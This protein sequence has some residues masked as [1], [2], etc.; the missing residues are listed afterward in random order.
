MSEDAAQA[1]APA[2]EA[3]KYLQK[4]GAKQFANPLE[5][6]TNDAAQPSNFFNQKEKEFGDGHS[7]PTSSDIDLDHLKV[8]AMDCRREAEEEELASGPAR[9]RIFACICFLEVMVNFAFPS[10]FYFILYSAIGCICV[11]IMSIF[12]LFHWLFP[13]I[14]VDASTSSSLQTEIMFYSL[15]LCIWKI[16]TIMFM[17]FQAAV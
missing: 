4:K 9:A 11:G 3:P 5:F 17:S 8:L 16:S 6:E 7:E 1:D 13:D 2:A 12:W 14:K 10:S 15:L